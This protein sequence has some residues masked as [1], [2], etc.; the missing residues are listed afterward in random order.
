MAKGRAPTLYDLPAPARLVS[1]DGSASKQDVA[2]AALCDAILGG[3]LGPEC[4]PPAQHPSASLTRDIARI[5]RARGLMTTQLHQPL[6][7]A[8]LATAVGI[9][10]HKLKERFHYLYNATPMALLLEMRMRKA[11]ALLE[12]G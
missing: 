4:R 2:H 7:L 5:E 10:E 9:N 3:A 6:T 12:S 8:Y 11:Y 1:P